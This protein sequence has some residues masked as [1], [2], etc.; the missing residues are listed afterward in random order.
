MQPLQLASMLSNTKKTI[1]VKDT[2]YDS[3]GKF[4]RKT[5]KELRQTVD[6][7]II[8]YGEDAK[9]TY[10][11]NCWECGGFPEFLVTYQRVETDKECEQRLKKLKK[12]L[13][14]KKE[15]R[16]KKKQHELEE[17]S[18]LKKKYGA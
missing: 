5:L 16:E 14:K 15:E 13:E 10:E 11:M 18:R 12:E 17:L 9:L 1:T 2:I 4:T 3:E 7:L 6:E 8:F